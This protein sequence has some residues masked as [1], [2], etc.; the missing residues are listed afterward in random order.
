MQ[1][2]WGLLFDFFGILGLV[3][4]F[5]FHMVDI[6]RPKWWRVAF[7]L[8]RAGVARLALAMAPPVAGGCLL[9]CKATGTSLRW[10]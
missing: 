8:G 2:L 5:V 4:S 7:A 1:I 9:L 10:G 6:F 3:W